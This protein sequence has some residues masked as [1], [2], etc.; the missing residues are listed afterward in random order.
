MPGLEW[1]PALAV[2][3]EVLDSQH[4]QLFA[5]I[6]RLDEV[7][8]EGLGRAEVAAVIDELGSYVRDHF[9]LEERLFA[10]KD[11]PAAKEHM[12]EH[13]AFVARISGFRAEFSLGKAE[14]DAKLLDFLKSWLTRHISLTDRKY[15][16]WLGDRA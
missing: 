2:G 11:Y 14:V 6:N 8:R 3:N 16:P 12:A 9:G 10:E 4:R 5:L 7:S 1:I 15:R 13:L